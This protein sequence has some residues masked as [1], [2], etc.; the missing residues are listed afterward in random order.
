MLHIVPAFSRILIVAALLVSA[1]CAA[2]PAP[3]SGPWRAVLHTPGGELPFDL[4]L[5]FADDAWTAAVRNGGERLE[6]PRVEVRGDSVILAFP[7]FASRIAAALGDDGRTLRGAWTIVRSADE[8]RRVR[9][10]ARA[11]ARPRFDVAPTDADA[12]APLAPGRWRVDFESEDID[13]VGVFEAGP[14][15]VV[16]GTFLTATGDY[17]YLEGAE[18]GDRLWLSTFDGAHAFL[19]RATVRADSMHGDFWSGAHWHETFTAVRDDAAALPDAFTQSV[20][21]EATGLDELRYPDLEGTLR[22][23]DDP[24]FAGRARILFVFGSWCPNCAD[25]TRLLVELHERYAPRGLSILGLAFESTGDL[26]RDRA[27]VRRY[28][29]QRDVPYP[30]LI[31]G[32][33]DKARAS[34][35]FPLLDQVHS[36][37]TTIF[38]EASGRVR[39]IHTGFSGPATGAAHLELRADFER[40]IG[41]LLEENG[42]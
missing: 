8:V 36:Y 14:G 1:G 21:N 32:L 5:G 37:P 6:V 42:D 34:A 20:W 39:A 15:S 2:D 29:E 22:G 28:A 13:A 41:E 17:R 4:E 27:Q 31:A 40:V 24:A 25:A 3:Q 19:F 9:F 33:R 10:E 16:T 26:D 38:L 7:A 30:I 35:A 18:V 11:G 23:L 12:R